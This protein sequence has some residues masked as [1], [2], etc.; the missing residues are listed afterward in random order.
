M[1]GAI[2]SSRGSPA[3]PRSKA[4]AAKCAR[5]SGP[6][7]GSSSINIMSTIGHSGSTFGFSS[8]RSVPCCSTAMRTDRVDFLDLTFDRLTFR[9]VKDRLRAVTAASPYGYIVTPNVD[10]IVR[11]RREPALRRLYDDAR[12]CLCD[13]RVLKLLAR[14]SGINLPLV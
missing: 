13:S 4:C 1:P 5:S 9:Q 3:M 6:S 11:L 12:L 14:L 2:A 7:G 8:P 10:H